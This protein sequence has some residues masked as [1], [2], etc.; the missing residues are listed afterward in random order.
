MEM[1]AALDVSQEDTAI[2]VV[3]SDG[4]MVA[5]AKVPTCPDAIAHWLAR[6]TQALERVGMETGPLAV[7]LLNADGSP[8]ADRM[9]RRAPCQWRA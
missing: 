7:W 5:E 4:T 6:R 9:H 1:F 3:T 8:S 2:C